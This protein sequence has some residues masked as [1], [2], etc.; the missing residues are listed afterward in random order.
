MSV[1]DRLFALVAQA[2]ESG[3]DA[4]LYDPAALRARLSNQAPDLHGEIQA[5]AAAIAMGAGPRAAGVSDPQAERAAISAE[6][7]RREHLSLAVVRPAVDVACLARIPAPPA[8]PSAGDAWIGDSIMVG[9][10][11]TPPPAP[12]AAEQPQGFAPPPYTGQSRLSHSV[13]PGT[14]PYAPRAAAAAAA[15]PFYQRIWF[16]VALGALLILT[17]IGYTTLNGTRGGTT[18]RDVAAAPAPQAPA[19]ALDSDSA[20]AVA[21]SGA[22]GRSA[23][24]AAPTTASEPP[25]GGPSLQPYGATMPV[26]H[27]QPLA[28]GQS[29]VGFT[30]VG[31]N[32]P[33]RG[34]VLLPAAGWESGD[35][36]LTGRTA[37]G[38]QAAGRGRYQLTVNRGIPMRVMQVAWSQ[39]E[40]GAGPTMV[41]FEGQAGRP[42]VQLS[43][44]IMCLLDGDNGRPVGCGRVQ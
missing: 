43:G 40:V 4:L 6:I 10:V 37:D 22:S 41:G 1:E 11:A 20:A 12:P 31:D 24:A 3:G 9:G 5:L 28:G 13:P 25:I 16:Y 42:D 7:A 18:R 32:G 36:V 29:A 17:A 38:A 26:L 34:A 44:S 39:D 35:S 27:V 8:P 21:D 30:L 15:A 23:A 33:I 2:R 19:A 14:T